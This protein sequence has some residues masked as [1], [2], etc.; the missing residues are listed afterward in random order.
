MDIDDE[1]AGRL[2]ST[3]LHR[4][5]VAVLE[6]HDKQPIHY[7]ALRNNYSSMMCASYMANHPYENVERSPIFKEKNI[8]TTNNLDGNSF[9]LSKMRSDIHKL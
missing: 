4:I 2:R 8:Q 6:G 1:A 3:D 5:I 9:S 7:H